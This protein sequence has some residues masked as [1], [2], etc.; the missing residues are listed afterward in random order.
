M[1][2]SKGFHIFIFEIR[3]VENR[4]EHTI[5]IILLYLINKVIHQVCSVLT[6]FFL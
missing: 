5:E 1:T 6:P 3:I 4:V 2:Q